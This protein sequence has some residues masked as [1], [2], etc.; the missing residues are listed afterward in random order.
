V[1]SLFV[2]RATLCM[3]LR[4]CRPI[5]VFHFRNNMSFFVRLLDRRSTV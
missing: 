5:S 2:D 4:A 1:W 3:I